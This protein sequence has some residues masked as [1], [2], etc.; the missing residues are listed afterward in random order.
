MEWNEE[1]KEHLPIISLSQH[2]WSWLILALIHQFLMYLM[3]FSLI[4][5]LSDVSSP[6]HCF[7]SSFF[8]SLFHVIHITQ[9]SYLLIIT[10]HVS[11]G[12][13]FSDTSHFI[14][15]CCCCCCCGWQNQ[16]SKFVFMFCVVFKRFTL[17]ASYIVKH[18]S[19]FVRLKVHSSS[20]SSLASAIFIIFCI[21]ASIDVNTDHNS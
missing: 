15:C 6:I 19:N 8:R 14:R 10:F 4:N 16:I 9:V 1:R 20:S 12:S 5:S 11:S 3:C 17:H 18:H 21:S 2:M 13:F 7:S